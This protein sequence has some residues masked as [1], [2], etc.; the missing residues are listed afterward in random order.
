[1]EKISVIIPAYNAAEYLG[2]ALSS[3]AAQ[4]LRPFEIIVVDDG[5]T[6]KTADILREFITRFPDLL[7]CIS[8]S[9]RGPA[10]ARNAGIRLAQGDLIAFLDADDLWD[11]DKLALQVEALAKSPEAGLVFC[12]MRHQ[13]AG[14]QVHASY[15]HERGYHHVGAGHIYENLLEE[16]FIFTPT[17]LV[18]REVLKRVGHFSENLRITEDYDL[19]LRIAQ[20]HS[21]CFVDRPLVTRRRTA[22]NLTNDRY[23]YAHSSLTLHEKLLAMN[24]GHPLRRAIIQ[25]KLNADRFNLG[26]LLFT[27][28]RMKE[29]RKSMGPTVFCKEYAAPALLYIGLSFLPL[30]LLNALRRNKQAWRNV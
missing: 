21:V 20:E 15:L 1:M 23:L 28:S 10:A 22:D 26:Y 18:R 13:V 14:Q 8:Q 5:S 12:D 11:R 19:W 30:P 3:A 9:N 16:N 2:E 17:V 29:A 4:T 24:E 6:D 27:Q 25:R 7:K